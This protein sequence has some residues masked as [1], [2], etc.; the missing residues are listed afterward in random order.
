MRAATAERV[1]ANKFGWMPRRRVTSW[2]RRWNGVGRQAAA[3]TPA[4]AVDA[5]RVNAERNW[6]MR[7][8]YRRRAQRDELAAALEAA[9]RKRSP[10]GLQEDVRAA[11]IDAKQT[12]TELEGCQG[13]T[14]KARAARD[15]WPRR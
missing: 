12:P 11:A 5:E 7:G 3:E 14:E 15:S 8:S 2:P 9:R 13:R 10:P 6:K 4:A 1:N